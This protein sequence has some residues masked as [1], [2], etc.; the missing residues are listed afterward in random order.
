MPGNEHLLR[1]PSQGADNCMDG[2]NRPEM[3]VKALLNNQSGVRERVSTVNSRGEHLPDDGHLF[4]NKHLLGD[5][6]MMREADDCD[7]YEDKRLKNGKP[8]DE[9]MAGMMMPREDMMIR[10]DRLDGLDTQ[11]CT[12]AD[13]YVMTGDR[14]HDT[15]GDV[16]KYTEMP[17]DDMLMGWDG[18]TAMHRG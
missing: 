18:H 4:G 15:N 7:D 6:K 16:L 13:D 8:G 12:G 2:E 17:R 11:P 14:R 1:Q 5:M 3:T 9:R 10:W